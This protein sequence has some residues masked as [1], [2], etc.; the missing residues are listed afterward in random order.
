M[1]EHYSSHDIVIY[2]FVDC[3]WCIAAKSLLENTDMYMKV[4]VKVI[5]LEPLQRQGKAIRAELAK[6]T[7]RTSLP[8]VWIG[9][10]VPI[11]GY[12]DG[13]PVGRGLLALHQSG[14]LMRLLCL[15]NC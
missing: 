9:D 2:S 10:G 7:N 8:S 13:S 5:E 12:T 3:P 11:G 1:Q 4:S 14:E 6:Q 15:D